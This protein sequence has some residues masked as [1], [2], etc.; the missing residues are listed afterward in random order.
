ML[1]LCKKMMFYGHHQIELE[2][3]FV[4]YLSSIKTIYNREVLSIPHPQINW[5]PKRTEHLVTKLES[6]TYLSLYITWILVH[7]DSK[8]NFLSNMCLDIIE[9]NMEI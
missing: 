7:S 6:S 5:N 4:F 2:D 3:K 9:M 1:R 8:Q